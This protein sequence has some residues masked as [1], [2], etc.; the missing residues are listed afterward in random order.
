MIT[1]IEA[2]F[3]STLVR[4]VDG[5]RFRPQTTKGTKFV[6]LHEDIL[7]EINIIFVS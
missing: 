3:V 5:V 7:K 4:T 6:S 2:P 1:V